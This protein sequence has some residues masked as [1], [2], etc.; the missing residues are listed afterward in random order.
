MF[1]GN[2]DRELANYIIEVILQDR[3]VKAELAKQIRSESQRTST[4][5]YDNANFEALTSGNVNLQHRLAQSGFDVYG[6]T[7]LTKNASTNNDNVYKKMKN[8]IR[9]GRKPENGYENRSSFKF[10]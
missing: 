6:R 2:L 5:L 1:V 8:K 9:Y 3:D 10:V 4:G 7:Y